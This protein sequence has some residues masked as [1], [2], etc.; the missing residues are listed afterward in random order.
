MK[1]LHRKT[2]AVHASNEAELAFIR[3]TVTPA[4]TS[5]GNSGDASPCRVVALLLPHLYTKLY[6]APILFMSGKVAFFWKCKVGVA[7]RKV[8]SSCWAMAMC[9]QSLWAETCRCGCKVW[10]ATRK[11]PKTCCAAHR[12]TPNLYELLLWQC[13]CVVHHSNLWLSVCTFQCSLWP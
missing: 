7:T 6:H 4:A 10:V 3:C 11:L 5:P 9:S 12:G 13:H 2:C 8:P 1:R